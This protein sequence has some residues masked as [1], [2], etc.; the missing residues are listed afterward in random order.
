MYFHSSAV[1]M[2]RGGWRIE[3]GGLKMKGGSDHSAYGSSSLAELSTAERL[4]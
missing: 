1:G 2:M 3:D 4:S